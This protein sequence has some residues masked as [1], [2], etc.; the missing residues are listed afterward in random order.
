MNAFPNRTL[1]PPLNHIRSVLLCLISVTGKEATNAGLTLGEKLTWSLVGVDLI[2]G[3]RRKSIATS[4]I[5]DFPLL[6]VLPFLPCI[7]KEVLRHTNVQGSKSQVCFRFY[8][9]LSTSEIVLSSSPVSGERQV[10]FGVWPNAVFFWSSRWANDRQACRADVIRPRR[11]CSEQGGA[12]GPDPWLGSPNSSPGSFP[13]WTLQNR[14][15]A[16]AK[17]H[18]P[19]RIANQIHLRKNT[20]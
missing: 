6:I 2:L 4:V 13:W 10:C 3:R 12:W 18:W 11:P 8:K 14:S 1:I 17:S 19:Q 16:A 5:R 20:N 7:L 9:T 15:P